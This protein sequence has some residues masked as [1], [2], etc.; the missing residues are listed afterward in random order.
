ME[1]RQLDRLLIV[2]DS[3]TKQKPKDVCD[4]CYFSLNN[5]FLVHTFFQLFVLLYIL[6]IL[7]P[8]EAKLENML[9]S[10]M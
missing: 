10:Q 9:F 4:A 7:Q 5:V 1:K 8:F 6:K 3:E 2:H